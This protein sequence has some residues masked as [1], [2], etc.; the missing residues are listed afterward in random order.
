MA[1]TRAQIEVG[2]IA[3][4]NERLRQK[5]VPPLDNLDMLYPQT[6]LE[7]M[8]DSEAALRT[9]PDIDA[10]LLA[11]LRI[12]RD[13]VQ[14]ALEEFRD[15]HEQRKADEPDRDDGLH[16]EDRDA[17]AKIEAD[18]TQIDAAIAKAEARDG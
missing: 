10:E 3:I 6:L 12:A 18:L 14:V 1:P 11:A 17:L 15:E 4:M 9:M 5:D 8:A 13:H 2:A 16:A 7:V